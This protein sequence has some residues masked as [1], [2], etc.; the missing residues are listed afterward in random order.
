MLV[1]GSVL[2]T[3][4]GIKQYCLMIFFKNLWW[5]IKETIYGGIMITRRVGGYKTPQASY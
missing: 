2:S 5:S 4:G 1:R 3:T